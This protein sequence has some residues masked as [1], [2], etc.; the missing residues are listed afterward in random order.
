MSDATTHLLLPYILAAQAQKHVTH[1]E[2]LRILD[3]LVQLSVLDRDL[4]APPGSPADGDRY[5]V[6]S[7]ATG[8]WAG[9]DLNVALWTDGAWLRLPPRTGWRAWVED[10]GLL[11]VYDG[12]GWTGTTPTALQ[13][14]SLLGV[15]GT[16]DTNNRLLVQSPGSLLNHEGAGHDLTINKA[17]VSDSASVLFQNGFT[18]VAQLGALGNDD[19]TVK[20]GASFM[21]TLVADRATGAVSF[22]QHPKFSAFLNYG[23]TVTAGAWATIPFNNERHDDQTSFDTGSGR[24]TAPHAGYYL[25]GAK[26]TL[27]NPG[28][29]VPTEIKVGLSING[30]TPTEDRIVST[31]AVAG[32]AVASGKVTGTTGVAVT[33]GASVTRNAVGRYTVTLDTAMPSADYVVL[34]MVAGAAGAYND[35]KPT[36]ESQT[37]SGFIVNTL[38]GDN[39]SSADVPVDCDF[40][41]A[42]VPGADF[43][44]YNPSVAGT[45]FLKLAAGDMVE[46]QA[47]C[48]THDG[49]I[50]ADANYFWGVQVA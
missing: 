18:A 24:F 7:G 42:V 46:A 2:A 48:V 16:A 17:D 43:G 19:F 22:P 34:A 29:S 44:N 38:V 26:F 21:T 31:T 8:D 5:I 20:V 37:A 41:F 3:G 45:A 39:S 9:W 32:F 47:F 13:N 49:R 1:N 25:F 12:A 15:N 10:E 35:V 27:E 14:L 11:L 28:S 33:T 40:F 30:A 6:G 36:V 4:T 23:Q 50:A